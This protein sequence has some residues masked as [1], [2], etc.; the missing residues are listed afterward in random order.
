MQQ[1][2]FQVFCIQIFEFI[3][4]LDNRIVVIFQFVRTLIHIYGLRSNTPQEDMSQCKSVSGFLYNVNFRH[5]F[6]FFQYFVNKSLNLHILENDIVVRFQFVR[7]L[8]HIYGLRSNT[9]Q[10]ALFVTMQK[11]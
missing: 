4:T 9:P 2:I 7:T 3:Y 11:C 5:N 6:I 10:E 1:H 8:M